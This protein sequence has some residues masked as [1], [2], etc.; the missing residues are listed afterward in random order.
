MFSRVLVSRRSVSSEAMQVKDPT[1]QSHTLDTPSAKCELE[2]R[3]EEEKVCGFCF[4]FP[5]SSTALLLWSQESNAACFQ[6]SLA[7]DD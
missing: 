5:F 4:Q 3:D 7:K 6:G 2:E 1:N